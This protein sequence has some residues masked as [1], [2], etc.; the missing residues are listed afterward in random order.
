MREDAAAQVVRNRRAAQ[1]QAGSAPAKA[2]AAP[3]KPAAAPAAAP[4]KVR[5]PRWLVRLA[6]SCWVCGARRCG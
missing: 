3:A 2:A 5:K 4:G 6:R 1:Q